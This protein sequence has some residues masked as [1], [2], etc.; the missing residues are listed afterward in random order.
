MRTPVT[1]G[2]IAKCFTVIVSKT[3]VLSTPKN[4]LHIQNELAE[5]QTVIAML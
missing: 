5:I 4:S 1:K 2:I 3:I